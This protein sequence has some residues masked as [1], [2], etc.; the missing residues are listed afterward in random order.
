MP[1]STVAVC[2]DDLGLMADAR[3]LCATAG[4]DAEVAG[5]LDARRWWSSST[6]VL[7][8][9]P[10]AAQL[11]GHGLPRRPGVALLARV[12]DPALW[13]FAVILGAE[14]VATLP[15]DDSAVLRGVLSAAAPTGAAPVVACVPASGGAGAST[16][17]VGLALA[18]AR[19]GT[20]TVLVDADPTGG[21]LDLLLGAEHATGLRWPDVAA[22]GADASSDAIL[23]GLVRAAPQLRL[24]S[25]DRHDGGRALPH[26]SWPSPGAGRAQVGLVVLDLP[27]LTADAPPPAA[28]LVLLVVR[29]GV[30]QTVAAA[31]SA[32][33]LR[34]AVDDVRLVVRRAARRV[35]AA[36]EI[37]TAVGLPLALE[38]SE[39]RRLNAAADDGQLPRALARMPFGSLVAAV[40]T[41]QGTAA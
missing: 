20:D 11:A 36:A 24:L 16:L 7:L 1:N 8:D 6:A 5:P 35:P 18:A 19:L 28:D 32:A 13:R 34:A 9:G 23:D 25:W 39:N 33:R 2:C 27:R 15:R 14:Q 21:G 38:L 10:A 29:A 40:M 37:A 31:E 3:R 26:P 30:R 12:D 22:L 17:A 4:M 41:T